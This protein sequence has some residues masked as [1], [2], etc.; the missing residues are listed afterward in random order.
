MHAHFPKYQLQATFQD[1]NLSRM[2]L[3][4]YSIWLILQSYHYGIKL[5]CIWQSLSNKIFLLTSGRVYF[6][7]QLHFMS[8]KAYVEW[9]GLRLGWA[10]AEFLDINQYISNRD[11][12]TFF[13][14]FWT[15]NFLCS[16]TLS[17]KK[18]FWRTF[19][20]PHQRSEVPSRCK[21]AA[22]QTKIWADFL[23]VCL[24]AEDKEKMMV[25]FH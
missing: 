24:V 23:I 1:T 6:S 18:I 10:S 19:P 25:N 21:A 9:N 14:C 17:W 3:W 5:N 7:Q 2:D 20:S 13:V 4:Y 8:C 12:S 22:G 11:L 15:P 16:L